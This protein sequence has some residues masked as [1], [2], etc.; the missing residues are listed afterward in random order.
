MDPRGASHRR[1]GFTILELLVVV[2]II[3][4]L[5]AILLPSLQSARSHAKTAACSS[6]FHH[7]GLAM[8]DYLFSSGAVYPPSYVYPDDA[9]GNWGVKNQSESRTYGYSHWS[10]FLY[11]EGEVGDRAFQCP[12][13]ERGGHPR[14]NP[15]LK[16]DDWE[17]GQV[18]QN[19]QTG[20]NDLQDKQAAR[21][22]YTANAAIMPR[23]KFTG[24]LSGGARVNTFVKENQL[25]RTGDIIL[26]AE[27]LDNWKAIGIV[28][29]GGV[30]SKSHRPINPYFHVG[31][32]FNEYSA[33]INAPG[34][35][36]G[37]Q[38]DQK[39]YGLLKLKD[40][41]AA[42]NLLDYSAGVAQINALGRHHPTTQKVYAKQ[43]GGSGNY[44]FC[45]GHV[46]N[47]TPLQSVE[48]RK[49]GDAYYS[50]SGESKILNMTKVKTGN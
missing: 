21:I 4:L 38:G 20:A 47:M 42:T 37:T 6:N 8:A 45:D 5:V 35:I 22:A 1:G 32:G 24:Q 44:L 34:F 43:Y 26:A 48:N 39:F 31:S 40:V 3:A 50:L 10:Y 36:Y 12:S 14:T 11:N 46:E 15:G 2:A 30:E 29:S 23:N 13:I 28:N 9:D 33:A 18:D 25:K 49:W 7:V 17:A 41:R 19:G 27:F 16:K